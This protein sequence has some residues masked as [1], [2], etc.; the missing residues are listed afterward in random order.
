MPP[1]GPCPRVARLADKIQMIASTVDTVLLYLKQP[2]D[3][4]YVVA[5]DIWSSHGNLQV[6]VTPADLINYSYV[7]G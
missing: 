3:F 2:N 7:G 1:P 4:Q 5:I 6:K